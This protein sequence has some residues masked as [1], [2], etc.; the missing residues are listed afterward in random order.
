MEARSIVDGL[1]GS[2]RGDQHGTREL[3]R[4]AGEIGT[5]PEGTETPEEA[6]QSEDHHAG[7]RIKLHLGCGEKRLPGFINIDLASN[8]WEVQPDIS[9]DIRKL[10]FEDGYAD[11]VHAYHV[12]EHF[13]RWEVDAVLAEWYRVLAPGGALVLELPCWDKIRGLLSNPENDV[14]ILLGLYG[15]QKHKSPEMVH[16]WCY[17]IQELGMLLQQTGFL[18]IFI[19]EP[20]FHRPPRDMRFEAWK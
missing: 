7:N 13:Y 6:A 11:E 14:S 15:T 4:D 5:A 2:N 9:C 12:L 8:H 1:N 18:E 3:R 16:K 17:A 10:P 19:A 20:R